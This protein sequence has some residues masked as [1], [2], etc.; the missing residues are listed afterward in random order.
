MRSKNAIEI[1]IVC[2]KEDYS[3]QSGENRQGV[4]KRKST[5]KRCIPTNFQRYGASKNIWKKFK[6]EKD[7]AGNVL[8]NSYSM[9]ERVLIFT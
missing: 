5:I 9:P 1:S 8:K 7:V 2:Q 4:K 3:D 6:N